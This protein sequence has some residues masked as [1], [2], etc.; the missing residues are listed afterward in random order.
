M[1]SNYVS[2]YAHASAGRCCVLVASRPHHACPGAY[3]Q[4]NQ[5]Q[6]FGYLGSWLFACGLIQLVQGGLAVCASVRVRKWAV[7]R[8]RERDELIRHFRTGTTQKRRC[9]CVL[10]RIEAGHMRA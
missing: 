7:R 4:P 10:S 5:T 3:M 6:N 8:R 1:V 2:I 9:V